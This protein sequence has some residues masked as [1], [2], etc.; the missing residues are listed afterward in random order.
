MIISLKRLNQEKVF[1]RN[2]PFND[3][4][5]CMKQK[6][7]QSK[8]NCRMNLIIIMLL[9]Q[10]SQNKALENRNSPFFI[11]MLTC[12]SDVVLFCCSI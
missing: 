8:S 2:F 5:H 6:E 11:I 7:Q 4:I 9:P 10:P 1:A 3:F 12:N